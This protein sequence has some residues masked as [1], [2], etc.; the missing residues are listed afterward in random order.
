MR[1]CAGAE[2]AHLQVSQGSLTLEGV[3]TWNLSTQTCSF[4]VYYFC[5]V[6]HS[7]DLFLF[8]T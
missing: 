4:I 7:A 5:S 2:H 1:I 3:C 6:L 8:N